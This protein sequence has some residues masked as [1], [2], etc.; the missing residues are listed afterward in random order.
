ME[1]NL[2]DLFNK[3]EKINKFWKVLNLSINQNYKF[4]KKR[5]FHWNSF[6]K[7]T[8]VN[9]NK[10]NKLHIHIKILN[11]KRNKGENNS[12]A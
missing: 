7:N 10:I 12:K 2:P 3:L 5:E 8:P 6:N 4:C 11:K 1:A 9:A